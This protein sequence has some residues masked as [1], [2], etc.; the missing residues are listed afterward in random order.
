[1][2]APN[3]HPEGSTTTTVTVRATGHVRRRLGTHELEFAFEGRTL[4]AFLDALFERYDLEDLL[5]AETE[6][7]AVAPGWAPSPD[8][9]DESWYSNP[10]GEKTRTYARVCVNG[11]FN[12][13]LDG[14]GTRIEDGD[15]ITLAF[16]FVFCV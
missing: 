2:V 14:F 6:A 4:G 12:E 7:D 11:R 10:E 1:M 3:G 15:R 8:H 9:L 16:P 5:L 13:T